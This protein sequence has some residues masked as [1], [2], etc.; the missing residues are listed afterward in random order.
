MGCGSHRAVRLNDKGRIWFG[1]A[2]DGAVRFDGTSFVT[3]STADGLAQN[4]V[5]AIHQ[6]RDGVMWFGS[7]GGGLSRF[8][9]ESMTFVW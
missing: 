1:T 8:D 3:C 4:R 2:N 6:D 5:H 9:G 7:F